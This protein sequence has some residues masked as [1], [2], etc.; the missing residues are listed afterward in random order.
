MYR[1]PTGESS[2][3]RLDSEPFR[4][5]DFTVK[6]HGFIADFSKCTINISPNNGAENLALA[7]CVSVLQVLCQP[8][9][10]NFE[11]LKETTS[12]TP[13]YISQRKEFPTDKLAMVMAFGFMVS[14]PSN[15]LLRKQFKKKKEEKE[16]S[17][18]IAP[19][20]G[21]GLDS[22]PM[23]LHSIDEPHVYDDDDNDD[24][25]EMEGWEAAFFCVKDEDLENLNNEEGEENT[26][27]GDGDQDGCGGCGGCGG[28]EGAW[29]GGGGGSGWEG[30]TGGNGGDSGG[31]GGG[32]SG[33]DIGGGDDGGGGWGGDSGGGDG[34]GW[35]GDS[36]GDDGGGGGDGGGCGG[37]CGGCGG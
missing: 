35:G 26:D 10:P 5:Y 32:Y 25:Y 9:P 36:G 22:E 3:L 2:T 4:Y 30:D 8:R 28:G 18:H 13:S 16:R 11:P 31:D 17:N 19:A 21:G 7:F 6:F 24:D 37:G 33:G 23:H 15:Y 1:L 14:T 20:C 29:D 34:G 12:D 27:G